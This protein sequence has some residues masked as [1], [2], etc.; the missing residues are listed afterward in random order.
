MKTVKAP[1]FTADQEAAIVAA[2]PLNYESATALAATMGKSAKSVVAKAIR[3]GVDYQKKT[4][5]TKTGAKIESKRDIVAEIE[6]FV[7]QTLS[8]LEESPKA[9]LVALRDFL[10]DNHVEAVAA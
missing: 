4:P 9:P 10:R 1:N 5:T 3:M 7:E 6:T 2:S 8:G